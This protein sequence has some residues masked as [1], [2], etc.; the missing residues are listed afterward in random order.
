MLWTIA[1]VLIIL[2]MLGLGSGFV[3]DEFIHVFY[4]A[5]VILLVVGLSQEVMINRRLRRAS[6]SHGRKIN[7]EQTV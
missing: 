6:R 5:A 7:I 4:I 1:V 2:W 3:M